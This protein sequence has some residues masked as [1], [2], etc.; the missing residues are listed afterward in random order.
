MSW[1]HRIAQPDDNVTRCGGCGQWQWLDQLC[2]LCKLES[3]LPELEC[4][5]IPLRP[6]QSCPSCYPSGVA[7]DA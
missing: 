5:G 2:D 7:A 1:R 4:C 6:G 3:T